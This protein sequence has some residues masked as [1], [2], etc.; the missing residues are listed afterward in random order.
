MRVLVR[1]LPLAGVILLSDVAAVPAQQV[2]PAG[3]QPV[4]VGSRVRVFAPTLRRDRYVGRVDSLDV[5]EIVLDTAGVRR[6]LGFEMGPVLVASH[7][8]LSIRT[9]AIERI[10]VSG[11]RTTRATTIRG[12]IIG[13]LGGGLLL[14]LGQLPEV[15]PGAKDFFKGVPLG[16]AIGAVAGGVVGYALGG[17]KWVPA[18]LPR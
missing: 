14:G 16:L 2:S 9:A 7:R 10:E 6:R 5:N 13:A 4:S 12:A 18:E 8:R 15:N 3:V 17:E 1:A 11:G